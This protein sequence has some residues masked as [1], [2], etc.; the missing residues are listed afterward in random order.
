MKVELLHGNTL[1]VTREEVDKKYYGVVNA[2]G[3][4]NFLHALKTHLNAKGFDLVKQRMWKDGHLMDE[5]Q[6]Y[7]RTRTEKSKAPHIYLY[8]GNWAVEGLEVAWNAGVVDVVV[9]FDV[10]NCQPDCAQMT[11]ELLK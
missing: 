3:E 9:E 8:N 4:S 2:A 7:L 5:M 10:F 1:R 11:K 6:Q